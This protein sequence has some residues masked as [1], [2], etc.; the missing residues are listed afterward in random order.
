MITAGLTGGIASGKSTVSRIL[1]EQG[2]YVVD[3]DEVAHEVILPGREAYQEI[4]DHFGREILA[5]DGQ[6][7]RAKLAPRVFGD[8]RQRKI[9]ERIIHPRV[10]AEEA[11]RRQEI[12]RKDPR[13]VIIFEAPLLIETGAHERVDKVI[14]VFTNTETQ[15]KRL[16]DRDGLVAEEA[17]LRMA[18]QMPEADKKGFADYL[19]DGTASL[20]EVTRRCAGI[21]QTL[22]AL[23][24]EAPPAG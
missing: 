17:R 9:A 5:G 19:V 4:L 6:I 22:V 18:A 24:R 15:L 11:R 13:A 2:A 12:S 20:T 3:A 16:M 7:D 21:Y 8:S 14:V 10:F 23:S 1:R